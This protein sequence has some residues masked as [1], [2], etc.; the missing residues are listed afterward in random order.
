MGVCF[1]AG[2]AIAGNP[3]P[4]GKFFIIRGVA[5]RI[6]KVRFIV[7]SVAMGIMKVAASDSVISLLLSGEGP[8]MRETDRTFIHQGVS[9]SHVR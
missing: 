5:I 1:A 3:A 2:A 6:M 9:Q 7:R 8:G 4:T